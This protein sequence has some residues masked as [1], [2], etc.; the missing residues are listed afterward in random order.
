VSVVCLSGRG[1]CYELTT[2][3]EESYRLRCVAVC[4]IETSSMS[5][6]I[7]INY[8]CTSIGDRS[9]DVSPACH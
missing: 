7:S 4:D 9:L 6:Q 2:R 5:S 1:L 3:P 8:D